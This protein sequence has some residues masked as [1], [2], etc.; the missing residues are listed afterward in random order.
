MVL[1]HK[2]LE[3]P[4]PRPSAK[5]PQVPLALDK[6][7]TQLMA[8]NR[9]QR[10]WDAQFVAHTLAELK[11]KVE[12]EEAVPMVFGNTSANP[13]RAPGPAPLVSEA[14][15]TRGPTEGGSSRARKTSKGKRRSSESEV[16]I[17]DARHHL[18]TGL[19]VLALV[20]VVGLVGYLLWPPSAAYLYRK[21]AEG[22]AKPNRSDWVL[23]Q[24]H[25]VSELE[26]RFP[27]HPYQ[28][29]V[30]AWKDRI[31]LDQAEGRERFL[32][33][34]NLLAVSKPK[35]ETEAAFQRTYMSV[36]KDLSEDAPIVRD[37]AA[38]RSWRGLAQVVEGR[39]ADRMW[40]LLV[41]SKAEK[42][43]SDMKDRLDAV[44]AK[45]VEADVA[46]RRGKFAEA[47]R[48]RDEAIRDYGRY[49]SLQPLIQTARLKLEASSAA[50]EEPKKAIEPAPSAP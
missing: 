7:T 43:E 1:M 2:H 10:P 6:L 8:K 19:L 26:R 48:L 27:E 3:E 50:P 9:D 37:E 32:V 28:A 15:V 45:L 46:D 44:T 21:A 40:W 31:L 39:A 41:N 13:M 29:E 30:Q 42:L 35:D 33:N 11:E 14:I 16:S 23:A 20:V 4:A 25:Y 5:N 17:P 47:R 22:M 38:L 34:P 12:R 49:Q 18:E 36:A 24:E